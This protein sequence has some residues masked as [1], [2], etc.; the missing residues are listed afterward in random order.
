MRRSASRGLVHVDDVDVLSPDRG[1]FSANVYLQ[2]SAAGGE[3]EVWPVA[4]STRDAL[5]ANAPAIALLTT[6]SGDPAA[7]RALRD[8]VLPGP[9]VVVSPAPGDLVLLCV[10]RPHAVRG[11]LHGPRLRLSLQAFVQHHG[12]GAPLTMEA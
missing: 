10:Q 8:E 6:M 12:H 9:P 4:L 3:L 1:A 11:P 5:L 2:N 7:Q